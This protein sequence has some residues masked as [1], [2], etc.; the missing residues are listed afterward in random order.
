VRRDADTT[1]LER[2]LA[3]LAGALELPAS[4]PLRD[5]VLRRL[6]TGGPAAVIA[7]PSRARRRAVLAVVAVLATLGA[8]LGIPA[9]RDALAGWLGLRGVT[10]QQRP[11]PLPTLPP[12]PTTVA[13]PTPGPPGSGLD[14]GSPTTL[15]AARGSL[16]FSPLVPAALGPPDAVWE[17]TPPAGGALTLVYLPG[18][19]RPA[20]S[21]QTGVSLLVTEFRADLAPEFLGKFVG[22]DATITSTSVAGQA[23]VWIAGAP[24]DIGFRD[25]DGNLQNDSLRL[26]SNTLLW[27]HGVLL[28]RV[29]GAPTLDAALAIA[30]SMA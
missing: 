12:S 18:P 11:G 13:S 19:G 1:A 16:G 3:D 9:W 5:V 30:D 14:L 7:L 20:A 17:R 24:H 21:A 26:A 22:S 6:R 15:E 23:G 28:L 8:S 27:Q 4:P 10:I 29:E 2:R 25:P